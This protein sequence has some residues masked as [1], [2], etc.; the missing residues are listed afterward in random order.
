MK[1]E[2]TLRISGR[3]LAAAFVLVAFLLTLAL[4]AG[5]TLVNAVFTTPQTTARIL[6]EE[7]F[8]QQIA[9]AVLAAAFDT[10][11]TEVT[12]A[13]LTVPVAPLVSALRQLDRQELAR[14]IITPEWVRQQLAAVVSSAIVARTGQAQG[15]A[16]ALNLVALIQQRLTGDQ[17]DAL[18][19]RVLGL[20][21]R[22]TQ[23]EVRRLLALR[24][25]R[26]S[27]AR[28]LGAI[29]FVCD[30]PL[31]EVEAREV[32]R[33]VLVLAL[34]GVADNLSA[35]IADFVTGLVPD[36]LS[37]DTPVGQLSL[38]WP[39]VQLVSGAFVLVYALPADITEPVEAAVA[40]ARALVQATG[41]RA[42]A[43]VEQSRQALLALRPQ[44]S[45]EQTPVPTLTPT[46]QPTPTSAAPAQAAGPVSL[47]GAGGVQDTLI[48]QM[49][50]AIQAITGSLAQQGA[51][52]SRWVVIIAGLLLLLTAVIVLHLVR[53]IR[54]MGLWTGAVLLSSG[55]ALLLISQR[56]AAPHALESAPSGALP[57]S[58]AGLQNSLAEA[59]AQA[60]QQEISGPLQAQ[61]VALAV[62]GAALLA[63]VLYTVWNSR[64]RKTWSRPAQPV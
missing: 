9:P 8:Y 44:A 56:F 7:E 46:P 31:A 27:G 63:A 33:N 24:A 17:A 41:D 23:I 60:V 36:N 51:A 42:R 10:L 2:P 6:A 40:Q 38:T 61:G 25:L 47:P 21:R 35:D 59:V 39:G 34:A 1:L 22:C 16:P 52:L 37:V 32:M 13:G 53:T 5:G 3:I 20:V 48:A 58:I 28:D 29:E 19:D 11:P 50:S 43:E 15:D 64:R 14:Q 55:L 26:G 30:P 49:D 4:F 12:V 54:D 62:A 45:Q 57:E 18:A